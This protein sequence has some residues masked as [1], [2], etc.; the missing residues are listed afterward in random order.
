MSIKKSENP[1]EFLHTLATPNFKS[2]N[3]F[4]ISIFRVHVSPP[5]IT[6][7][8]HEDTIKM[9]KIY[10]NQVKLGRIQGCPNRGVFNEKE[11]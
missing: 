10:W 11:I 6:L 5:Y 3:L 1:Q 4:N 8:S 9:M 7:N 2:F